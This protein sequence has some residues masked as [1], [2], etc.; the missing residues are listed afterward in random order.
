M[1]ANIDSMM[2]LGETPWHREGVKLDNPP[3]VEEAIQASGLDWRVEKRP[4]FYLNPL[5]GFTENTDNAELL[6]KMIRNN[7]SNEIFGGFLPTKHYVTVRMDNGKVLGNVSEKYE[8]LQNHDAFMPFRPLVDYGYTFETAGAIQGGKKIW[9][10][11]KAPKGEL[12]GDDTIQPY[13]LL[14]TSHDG[15]TGNNMRDTMVRVVCQN[16][17]DLALNRNANVEY[18]F[19]HT[20]NIKANIKNVAN[21]IEACQGNVAL[22]IDQ[23]NR[24]N[25]YPITPSELDTYLE[26]VIPFLKKRNEKSIPELGINVRNTAKPTYEQIVD[27]FYFGR[28]NKGKT[29]WDAYNAITEY[30]THDKQYKD[31]V[32]STQ[33]GQAYQ[34]KVDALKVANKMIDDHRHM[35]MYVSDVPLN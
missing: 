2:Y 5:T 32:K 30:Y 9:I 16:T 12:V 33:F 35:S 11:A 22:A 8:V 29:L 18:K 24:M 15:S 20:Q 19:K 7:R 3:T 13:I 34:Y 1:P 4:T 23:M 10:L 6:R 21:N 26:T 27:N 17:L 28:G 14:Y 25:E 31:W